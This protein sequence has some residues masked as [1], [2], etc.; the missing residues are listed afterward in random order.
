MTGTG[1]IAGALDGIGMTAGAEDMAMGAVVIGATGMV[2]V[3]V[4]AGGAAA[5]VDIAAAALEEAE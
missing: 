4:Y 1:A 3:E 2:A 5:E